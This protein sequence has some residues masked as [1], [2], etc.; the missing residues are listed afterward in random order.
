MAQRGER[1]ADGD[2]EDRR[3]VDRHQTG[4][5]STWT[6]GISDRIVLL[7]RLAI[8]SGAART[9]GMFEDRKASHGEPS[10]KFHR[11]SRA[12]G[13]GFGMVSGSG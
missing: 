12:L 4:I 3:P 5:A 13:N 11:K 8:L 10:R 6:V 9:P 1:T 2:V 7:D